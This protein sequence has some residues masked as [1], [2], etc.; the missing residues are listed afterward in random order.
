M[1]EL[2]AY[3]LSRSQVI[4]TAQLILRP[5]FIPSYAIKRKEATMWMT[6]M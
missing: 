5:L 3:N 4:T 1:Y 6:L 2:I